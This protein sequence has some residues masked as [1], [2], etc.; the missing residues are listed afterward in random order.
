M[1]Y[2]FSSSIKCQACIEK[3]KPVLD[4]TTTIEKWEVDLQSPQRTLTINSDQL[5]VE[6]LKEDLKKVG[7][8]IQ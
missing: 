6:Q 2:K 4:A 1:E 3:V 7:Y 5:N 8:T